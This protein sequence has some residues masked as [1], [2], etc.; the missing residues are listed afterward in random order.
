MSGVYEMLE[1]CDNKVKKKQFAT[2]F[3]WSFF[4]TPCRVY[5]LIYKE[6][7]NEKYSKEEFKDF[8]RICDNRLEVLKSLLGDLSII[9]S[10]IFVSLAVIASLLTITIPADQILSKIIS[11]ELVLFLT[12]ILFASIVFVMMC[13]GYIR[14]Q[15]YAWASF[16]EIALVRQ[17]ELRQAPR[18]E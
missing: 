13:M 10:G 16:R 18:T 15:L 6:F 7:K 1:Y 2:M 12:I 11:H 14:T 5:Q 9:F 17:S 3:R 4:S 8:I